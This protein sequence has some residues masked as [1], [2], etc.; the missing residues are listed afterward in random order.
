MEKYQKSKDGGEH[1]VLKPGWIFTDDV[2]MKA[3]PDRG[4]TLWM[5]NTKKGN[6]LQFEVARRIKGKSKDA[7]RPE[8]ELKENE[9]E[10]FLSGDIR[11]IVTRTCLAGRINEVSKPYE[12]R[13]TTHRFEDSKGE[14]FATQIRD[15]GV[16]W[17]V[18]LAYYGSKYT[19]GSAWE[20]PD[21]KPPEYLMS[22]RA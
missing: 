14:I 3:G 7:I 10:F 15:S 1:A 2:L 8:Y 13:H 18:A 6:S 4:R 11:V 12:W 22:T 19:K 17:T 21:G 9:D 16:T 20:H 5:K